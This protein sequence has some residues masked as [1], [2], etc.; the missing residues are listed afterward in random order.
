MFFL[1]AAI[2]DFFHEV[3]CAGEEGQDGAQTSP[4]VSHSLKKLY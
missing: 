3:L 2:W 1:S 4:M